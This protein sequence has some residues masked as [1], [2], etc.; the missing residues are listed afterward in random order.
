MVEGDTLTFDCRA[1]GCPIPS[2][3]WQFLDT[4]VNSSFKLLV[5]SV[6]VQ[7]ESYQMNAITRMSRLTIRNTR[8]SQAGF[9]QCCSSNNA[10][11]NTRGYSA[12]EGITVYCK[13]SISLTVNNDLILHGCH[14]CV[15]L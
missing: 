10:V 6:D 2:I 12:R 7:M 4:G 14:R 15:F 13:K 9:Y 11:L 3:D 1:V 8:H 5:S